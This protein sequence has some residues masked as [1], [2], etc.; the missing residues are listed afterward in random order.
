MRNENYMHNLPDEL[1]RH[2]LLYIA[3]DDPRRLLPVCV[4][5][6][7]LSRIASP[8]LVYSWSHRRR[9]N[10]AAFVRHLLHNPG[11]RKEVRRLKLRSFKTEHEWERSW[12]PWDAPMGR[13]PSPLSTAHSSWS[14]SPV[15]RD[16]CAASYSECM[17]DSDVTRQISLGV[18]DA[19]M[20]LLLLWS[21]NLEYL[22]ISIPG[23]RSGPLS[24]VLQLVDQTR[25]VA[26]AASVLPF[27][28]LRHISLK[29]SKGHNLTHQYV[30]L[31]FIQLPG[32]KYLRVQ[33]MVS[34]GAIQTTREEDEDMSWPS[35]P[36]SIEELSLGFGFF[37]NDALYRLL[38][39]CSRLKRLDME[40]FFVL[41]PIQ[42]DAVQL[43]A[44]LPSSLEY[45]KISDPSQERP[46]DDCISLCHA[47][48]DSINR[49][50]YLKEI[51]FWDVPKLNRTSQ[52][53]IDD[54]VHRASAQG[55]A[56]IIQK[57]NCDAEYEVHSEKRCRCYWTSEQLRRYENR[58]RRGQI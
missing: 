34:P 25:E 46:V 55:V 15:E 39:S 28:K 11:L 53:N 14:L 52:V 37:S 27:R 51:N 16:A 50:R 21:V 41:G 30:I 57:P 56:L 38:N 29:S 49:M 18:P 45:L 19:L 36:S 42:F 1:L 22:E 5:N 9:T 8:L 48:L 47:L 44:A 32:V 26:E 7:R 58:R 20:A 12:Q 6:R 33:S 10:L 17:A 40:W 43:A 35:T 24:A 31:R 54:L 3:L 4:T 13:H 2:V 23:R